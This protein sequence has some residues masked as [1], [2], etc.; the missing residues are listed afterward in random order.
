MDPLRYYKLL[1][2]YHLIQELE[3][4]NMSTLLVQSPASII[5]LKPSSFVLIQDYMNSVE[6]ILHTKVLVIGQVFLDL[7]IIQNNKIEGGLGCRVCSFRA[8][9]MK[10]T[11]NDSILFFMV[12]ILTCPV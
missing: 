8:I 9:H 10:L 2:Q 4:L 7:I 6:K 12:I 5:I 3:V 11:D 1:P